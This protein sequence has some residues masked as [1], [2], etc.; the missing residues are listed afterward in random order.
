MVIRTRRSFHGCF[1]LTG[2]ALLIAGAL[3][4]AHGQEVSDNLRATVDTAI[5]RM[6][7]ALVRIHVVSTQYR[8]G[9]EIKTRSVGSGAIITKD[10]HLIS[11]HHVAGHAAR[12]VCTLWNREEIE[13]ELIGT[14]PSTD[15]SVLKLKPTRPREFA[16]ATFGDSSAIAVGD[17]VLALGSPMALSQSVT[18][19]II[20]NV[21]MIMPRFFG[22]SG[23][24][25]LDG[26]DVGGLVRW[27]GH[28][29][30][31]YGGNS[32]G[33]LVNLRGEIIGINEISFGLGGAIP[34]N[35]AR[36]VAEEIIEHGKVR[37]S[38]IGVDVQPRFKFSRHERGVLISGV[39]ENSP[40]E[41]AGIRAGDV[42]LQLNETP[43]N[44]RYD[45][46]MPDFMRLATSLPIG[47]EVAALVLRGNKEIPV[48]IKPVER[49]ELYPKQR[50][51]K[52]WGLTVR[53]ISFLIAKEMKR[54]NQNGV[55][56][57]SV[58]PG[59]PAGD[60]KP[61]IESRDVLV[62]V[63]GT[64][65]LN[66]ADL[67]EFTRK[68]MENTKEPVPVIA[69]F[70][71]KSKR[72][73]TVARVGIQELRDPGLEVTKAWMPVE[74][75]VISRDIAR[76]V[77]NPSL[78]GFYLTKVYPNSTAEKAGLQ[79]GDFITA[80]DGEKLNAS[81]PEHE[82]EFA[83]LMRQY[84]IGAT[85]ELSVLRDKEPSKVSVELVRSPKVKREMK[86][87]RNEDFEFTVR[88]VAFFDVAEEQWPEGQRGALVEEV[89]PGSWAELGYLYSGDL[90]LE[91][92]GQPVDDV[93]ALKSRM[94]KIASSK[95]EFV[96]MKV[97]RGIH[98]TYLELEPAWKD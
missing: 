8:E 6:R 27:I 30:A 37:R 54:T 3:P 94:E 89:K 33:P 17:Y 93:E 18:L 36:A 25:R 58:R 78:T 73:L 68:L 67:V 82:E 77:G 22:A 35:L 80:V 28:D 1:V 15:I 92:E 49:G 86:K 41:E 59:G 42:L 90:I 60:A 11:N 72:F 14:D 64:P 81:G 44:V 84:E 70:E 29:A 7:P 65:I 66:T 12:M 63:N 95:K 85:V 50:E 87:Y 43:T 83:A 61:S 79:P 98:T 46:E 97:L 57:T 47:A 40:A 32:G 91:V 45:E 34:G 21:E 26:E 51:I 39:I 69:T 52:E 48:R 5:A 13:A 9:R 76:Q 88:D 24:M 38:W 53:D 74:T 16:V 10:G 71:R 20:S 31:I 96:V 2:C 19:G 56:V 4:V 23:R 55:L 62:E 75:H